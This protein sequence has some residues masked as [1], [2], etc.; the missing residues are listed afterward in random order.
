MEP[1]ISSFTFG[2]KI[3]SIKPH[4]RGRLGRPDQGWPKRPLPAS[5][6]A[7]NGANP[8]IAFEILP[9]GHAGERLR[10]TI[11]PSGRLGKVTQIVAAVLPP[12]YFPLTRIDA[13]G[14]LVA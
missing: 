3:R 11:A 10:S 7:G 12:R 13:S 8:E 1:V 5:V 6:T 14:S 4:H 9:R 2:S